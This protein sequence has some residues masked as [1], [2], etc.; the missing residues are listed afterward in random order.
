MKAEE[1]GNY[2]PQEPQIPQGRRPVKHK[3]SNSQGSPH[4][5][6]YMLLIW[7][8]YPNSKNKQA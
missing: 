1:L 3:S 8:F 5:H 7:D 6:C 4:K 2:S